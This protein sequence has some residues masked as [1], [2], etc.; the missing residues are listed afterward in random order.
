MVNWKR[1]HFGQDNTIA[2]NIIYDP[3]PGPCGV[4]LKEG[5]YYCESGVQQRFPNSL[6]LKVLEADSYVGVALQN[7]TGEVIG[8]LCML[9]SQ[10][11]LDCRLHSDVLKIFAAPSRG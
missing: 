2:A 3:A 10:P 5:M 11:I 9:D 6:A 7:T 8:N 1:W 4:V